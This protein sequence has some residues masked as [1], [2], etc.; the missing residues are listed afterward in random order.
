MLFC[1]LVALILSG[2]SVK[3]LRVTKFVKN[4]KFEGV[5]FELDAKD[6]LQRQQFTKY[7]R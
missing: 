5:W 2:S 6:C 1:N 7:L 3:D 4:I